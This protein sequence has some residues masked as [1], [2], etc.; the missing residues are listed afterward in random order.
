VLKINDIKLIPG[1]EVVIPVKILEFICTESALFSSDLLQIH[2]NQI[3]DGVVRIG[4]YSEKRISGNSDQILIKL[5]FKVHN[6]THSSHSLSI[7]DKFDDFEGFSFK[8]GRLIIPKKKITHNKS[9]QV[10]YH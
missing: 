10:I 3:A 7:L 2:A 1:E 4:G 9:K 6:I 8:G 5:V